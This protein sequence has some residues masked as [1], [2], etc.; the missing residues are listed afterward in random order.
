MKTIINKQKA[1][2]LALICFI[3][4]QRRPVKAAINVNELMN[5]VTAYLTEERP[6]PTIV[7]DCCFLFI[8][9]FISYQVGKIIEKNSKNIPVI[10]SAIQQ[11][12]I[13]N[14]K[15]VIEQQQYS[16]EDIRKNA[17]EVEVRLKLND[18]LVLDGEPGVYGAAL[19]VRLNKIKSLLSFVSVRLENKK[20]AERL[21]IHGVNKELISRQ[22]NFLVE[23]LKR[24]NIWQ[25]NAYAHH[26]QVLMQAM[27]YDSM[28][29]ELTEEKKK[30]IHDQ[31][32]L[33]QRE[34]AGLMT[35]I[36]EGGFQVKEVVEWLDHSNKLQDCFKNIILLSNQSKEY[37]APALTP[38][39]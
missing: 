12:S 28:F 35:F 9:A 14:Q 34:C 17:D 5:I 8:I 30:K 25:S 11:S 15:P 13:P 36:C 18:N 24:S 37:F 10:K 23:E 6:L 19:D 20:I 4:F 22:E 32:S 3:G 31:L 33:D 1:R 26:G 7:L 2:V 16:L 21:A 39:S 27:P 29:Q 38:S